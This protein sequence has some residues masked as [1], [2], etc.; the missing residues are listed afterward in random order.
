MNTETVLYGLRVGAEDWQE[1]LITT[2]PLKIEEAT[3]WAKTQGFDRFRVA[4]IDLSQ[5]PDFGKTVNL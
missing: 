4:H 2:N 1:E 5:K 3:A